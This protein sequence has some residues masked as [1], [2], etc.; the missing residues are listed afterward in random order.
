M[1]SDRQECW[2]V[3][4]SLTFALMRMRVQTVLNVIRSAP[5]GLTW[6]TGKS[7]MQSVPLPSEPNHHSRQKFPKALRSPRHCQ[8][9]CKCQCCDR[10]LIFR[11]VFQCI[12][13]GLECIMQHKLGNPTLFHLNI[14]FCR[15]EVL[16]LLHSWRVHESKVWSGVHSRDF[17]WTYFFYQDLIMLRWDH[18]RHW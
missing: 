8:G 11:A 1:S 12:K 14:S 16:I 5:H 6:K 7:H 10:C 15:I 17:S 3:L 2:R 18:W 4:S 9:C 13:L